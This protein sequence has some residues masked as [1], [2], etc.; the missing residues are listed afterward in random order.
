MA[1]NK[2][3][4]GILGAA[5]IA[6]EHVIPA[7]QLSSNGVVTALASRDAAKGAALRER[8]NI[9]LAFNSYEE[10]LAAPDIDAVYIPLPNSMH[11]EWTRRAIAAGKHVLCDKPLALR[12]D[13]IDN[14]I[15]ARN[16]SGLVVGEGFMVVHHP[17]WQQVKALLATGHL[18]TLRMV[19]S[20]FAFFNVDPNNIRNQRELGGGALRDIGV[21]PIVTT[22]F[23]TGHEP[24]SAQASIDWDPRFRVDRFA[25]CLLDFG[26]F[27]L[28]FYC[29]TQAAHRQHV[30]FHGDK[31]WLRLDAPFNAG[32]YDIARITSRMT[33]STTSE[34]IIFPQINQYQLM[35]ENFHAAI[36]GDASLVFPLES[37]RANQ[38]VID[39]IFA[40]A[41]SHA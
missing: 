36:R 4:W 21:Y 9:A 32:V 22:R 8:F 1:M 12:A 6:R 41:P 16:A 2:I 14:L 27:Q 35:I 25:I 15:A 18:G 33:G 34:E 23:A 10:L 30:A 19:E 5:K 29:G 20:S 39:M 24:V 37:S 28:S 31:G 13:E 40:A 38:Q 3:R 17:Q 7:I 26:G 11:I